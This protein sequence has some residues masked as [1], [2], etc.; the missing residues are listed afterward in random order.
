MH[1]DAE[2]PSVKERKPEREQK[3]GKSRNSTNAKIPVEHPRVHLNN[4]KDV[5]YLVSGKRKIMVW[6]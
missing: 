2:I 6:F 4:A 1:S 5:L 3:T